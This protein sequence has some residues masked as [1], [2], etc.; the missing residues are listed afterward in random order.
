MTPRQIALVKHTWQVVES[1]ADSVSEFF[2]ARVFELDPTVRALFKKDMRAQGR[3]LN[4]VITLA[5]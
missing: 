4:S 1:Q 5:V 2:Y 3:M